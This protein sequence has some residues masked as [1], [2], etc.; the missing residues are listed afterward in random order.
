MHYDL[1]YL[2]DIQYKNSRHIN[3]KILLP[4]K[5]QQFESRNDLKS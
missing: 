3:T 5:I 2:H 1:I 4:E